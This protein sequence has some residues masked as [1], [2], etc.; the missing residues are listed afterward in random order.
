M[1]DIDFGNWS[2]SASCSTDIED[3]WMI[4]M[5]NGD[6]RWYARYDLKKHYFIDAMPSECTGSNLIQEPLVYFMSMAI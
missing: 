4:E 1:E 2:Y 3:I 6:K 5:K